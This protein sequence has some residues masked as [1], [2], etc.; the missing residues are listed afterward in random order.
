MVVAKTATS[1]RKRGRPPAS[2]P[3]GRE[4][5]KRAALFEFAKRG[6][7]GASIEKI[8]E[9][10]GV[11]KPLVH[12]HF[13]SKADLWKEAVS[14]AFDALRH[15]AQRFAIEFANKSREDVIDEFALAIVRFSAENPSLVRIS[16]DETRQGGDR[17]EWLKETYLLPLHEITTALI[18]SIS[19][20]DNF[21][22][23]RSIAS[24]L[25]PSIFGAINFPYIDA[26]VLSDAYDVDVFSDAYIAKQAALIAMLIRACIEHTQLRTNSQGS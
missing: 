20:S 7:K 8:A 23:N 1:K 25:T 21:E 12:Y 17:A 26:D 5:I 19:G 16:T 2:K 13:A 6:F 18:S 24:H 9:A 22:E 11:A 3:E 10:A 4:D 14:E 15:E